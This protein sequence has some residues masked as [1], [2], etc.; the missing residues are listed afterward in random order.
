ML[1][2]LM[3][4]LEGL[5]SS[6]RGQGGTTFTQVKVQWAENQAKLSAA[7]AET[8]GAIRES[9]VGYDASDSQAASKLAA[10]NQGLQLPL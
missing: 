10:S 4:K 9:G 8:A 3:S 6:W 1:K 7:L 5:E 2:E